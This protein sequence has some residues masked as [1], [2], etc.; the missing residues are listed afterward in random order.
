M[1]IQQA[2]TRNLRKLI[3]KANRELH[4]PQPTVGSFNQDIEFNTIQ[5]TASSETLW[6]HDTLR[7]VTRRGR[8]WTHFQERT[9][10]DMLLKSIES[11]TSSDDL[12]I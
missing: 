4:I 11:Q 8:L 9:V 6:V 12:A 1:R 3:R 5:V 7:F 10:L 2:L